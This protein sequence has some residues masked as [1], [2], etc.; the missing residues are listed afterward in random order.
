M[1]V[2]KDQNI[3]ELFLTAFNKWVDV[4]IGYI[5]SIW[6]NIGELEFLSCAAVFYLREWGDKIYIYIYIEKNGFNFHIYKDSRA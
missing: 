3:W 5:F 1:L 4:I 6:R 2:V